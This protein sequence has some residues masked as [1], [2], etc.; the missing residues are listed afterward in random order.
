M[1]VAEGVRSRRAL[2][3]ACGGM[4]SYDADADPYSPGGA[5]RASQNHALDWHTAEQFS[6][7]VFVDL[8]TAEW[9]LEGVFNREGA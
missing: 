1:G 2:C 6:A 5:V 9:V 3:R 8:D 4:F 7:L